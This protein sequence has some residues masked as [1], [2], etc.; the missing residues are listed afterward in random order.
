MPRALP[1]IRMSKNGTP[2]NATSI[3][4]LL[5]LSNTLSI[6]SRISRALHLLAEGSNSHRLPATNVL[7]LLEELRS[8]LGGIHISGNVGVV[9]GALLEDTNAVMVRAN[10]VVG[11]VEGGGDSLVGVDQDARLEELLVDVYFEGDCYQEGNVN[12]HTSTR[13]VAI[14]AEQPCRPRSSRLA[15]AIISL[16]CLD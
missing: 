13:A 15:S 2:L 14:P 12:V 7:H 1:C 3:A 10:S 11:V 8:R 4:N 5:S 16:A 6:A 9:H